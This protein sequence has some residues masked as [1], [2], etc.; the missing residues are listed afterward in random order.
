MLQFTEIDRRFYECRHRSDDSLL[1]VIELLGSS[2]PDWQI[3]AE[4]AHVLSAM[5]AID[6]S[7]DQVKARRI[8]TL[9]HNGAPA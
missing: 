7:M 8:L 3:L 6:T 1:A 4:G 9:G 5:F 2:H